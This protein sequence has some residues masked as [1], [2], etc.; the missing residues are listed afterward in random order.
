MKEIIS[1]L[2]FKIFFK[3]RKKID[4]KVYLKVIVHFKQ[5][6]RLR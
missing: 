5:T 3:E 4:C 1:R 6:Q 2:Y